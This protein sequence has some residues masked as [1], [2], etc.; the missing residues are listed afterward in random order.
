MGI[1]V[2]VRRPDQWKHGRQTSLNRPKV[3]L[4][5]AAAKPCYF[6]AFPWL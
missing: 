5:M 4:L 1:R 2:A 6:E 3:G